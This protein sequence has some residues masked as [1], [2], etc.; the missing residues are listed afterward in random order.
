MKLTGTR[1]AKFDVNK[2]ELLRDKNN[3]CVD[4]APGEPG[5]LLFPIKASVPTSRFIG[6]NDAAA[7]K[8]KILNDA[9]AKGDR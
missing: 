3:F 1:I 5:E 2:D 6:Y 9:F 4:C 7:T 8:K